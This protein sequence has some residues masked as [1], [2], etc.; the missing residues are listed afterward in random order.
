[1]TALTAGD[2]RRLLASEEAAALPDHAPVRVMP[3]RP[4]PAGAPEAYLVTGAAVDAL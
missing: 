3:A 4:T 2:L 1:M